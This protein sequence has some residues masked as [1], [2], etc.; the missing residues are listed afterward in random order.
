M[1]IKNEKRYWFC[2]SRFWNMFA[3]FDSQDR[4]E[5][6]IYQFG[7]WIDINQQTPP[8]EVG[9]L[10]TDGK[11]IVTCELVENSGDVYM[12]PVGFGGWECEF[13]F[14]YKDIKKWM[15]LPK[16]EE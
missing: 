12:L 8:R 14:S 13:N 10:V 1:T 9:I 16:L 11:E 2:G 4:P 15:P 7:Q 6:N 3:K 5:T